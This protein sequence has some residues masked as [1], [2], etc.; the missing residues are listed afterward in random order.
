M[1]YLLALAQ[2]AEVTPHDRLLARFHE[3]FDE[4]H[5]GEDRACLTGLV[6]ELK[7]NWE[8]FTPAERAEMTARLAP[9]KQDLLD[10][11]PARGAVAPPAAA[12]A[13]TCWGQ[14]GANRLLG[15]HFSVE[16]NDDAGISE[17]TAQGFLE[18]LE[19]SYQREVE[20][21]GWREP[22]GDGQYL[23][24]AYIS[25]GNYASAY[26]TIDSCGGQYLPYIVAYA[27]SFSGSGTWDETMAAHEF[28]HALQFGYS[29]APEFWW[30]EAT[31]TYVEE[32]VYPDANWWS[33]YVPGYSDN[34]QIAMGASSQDDQDVFYHMYG[35]AIWGFYLD[36]YQGG[37]DI[38]RQIWEYAATQR[39]Y[40]ELDAEEAVEGVGIDFATAYADFTA[41]NAAMDYRE[42]RYFSDIDLIDSFSSLPVDA[43]SSNRSAPGGYGQNYFRVKAD[44][45]NGEDTLQVTFAGEDSVD[46]MVQV[47]EVDDSDVSRVQTVYSADDGTA[48][49]T[50]EAFGALDAYVVV[51][52][53][54][55]TDNTFDYSFTAELVAASDDG[56]GD[57]TGEDSGLVDDDGND[58][59]DD[60]KDGKLELQGCGCASTAD[61]GAGLAALALGLGLV[62]ARRRRS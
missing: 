47:V 41:R 3:H 43:E 52:P 49:A 51:S 59:G 48:V 27:G 57:D 11:M 56:G 32:A 24:M 10:E 21:L 12:A 38:V 30:W 55:H 33:S 15:E 1:I 19:Y 5:E 44:A 22:L 6:Q 53:L 9:W 18:A 40:Y 8:V 42:H 50:L 46:W 34:P 16:W 13:D 31:A 28:N 35:M 37:S 54:K 58:P 60:V 61:S 14:Y 36:E 26:T 23:M 4:H 62:A 25:R 2:A 20:E 7:L 39:G 17:A 29:F 45:G